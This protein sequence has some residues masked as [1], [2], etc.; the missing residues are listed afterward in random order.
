MKTA[1]LSILVAFG[2]ASTGGTLSAVTITN[3]LTLDTQY[4]VGILNGQPEESNPTIELGYAQDI[5][6]LFLGEK[7]GLPGFEGVYEANETFNYSGT[8]TST[9]PKVDNSG[10]IAAGWDWALAKYDG[11]QGGYVLFALNGQAS[12]IPTSP[13]ELWTDKPGQYGISHYT[14]FDGGGGPPPPPPPPPPVPEGGAG[15]MLFG[16]VLAG[17]GLARKVLAC[18]KA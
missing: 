17:M 15:V 10:V 2:V 11:Q 3:P 9:G 12:T 8:I 18:A 13:Y 4:L 1:F 7:T 14:L 5:L 16:L 6:D